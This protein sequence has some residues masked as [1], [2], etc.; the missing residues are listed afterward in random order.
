M[1]EDRVLPDYEVGEK[2]T[3][4]R[5]RGG[6]S[7]FEPARLE[8]LQAVLFAL[9]MGDVEKLCLARLGKVMIEPEVLRLRNR[10]AE[11]EEELEHRRASVIRLSSE[12]ATKKWECREEVRK[13]FAANILA[14]LGLPKPF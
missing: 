11:L 12:V 4:M 8:D 7:P 3:L 9:P 10:V 14:T 13:E 5:Y 1:S 2:R 6:H